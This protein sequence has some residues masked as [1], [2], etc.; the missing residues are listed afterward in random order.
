MDGERR[1]AIEIKRRNGGAV[2]GDDS[3][4]STVPVR[5]P[6][7]LLLPPLLL[8]DFDPAFALPS[9]FKINPCIIG[10]ISKF[11][12]LVRM[13]CRATVYESCRLRL[14]VPTLF[15]NHRYPPLSTAETN[16]LRYH[17]GSSCFASC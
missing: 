4:K 5:N 10:Q 7:P 17:R 1:R 6:P 8:L 16:F 11:S 9:I 3:N 2:A 15:M 14:R 12:L 13:N